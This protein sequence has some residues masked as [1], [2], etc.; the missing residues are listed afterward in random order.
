MEKSEVEMQRESKY[1]IPLFVIAILMTI[2]HLF[3]LRYWQ[4][5][6]KY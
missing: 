6:K 1:A 3:L 5:S 4:S 2:D